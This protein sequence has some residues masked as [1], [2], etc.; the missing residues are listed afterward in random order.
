[1]SIVEVTYRGVVESETSIS[2]SLIR[3]FLVTQ[4]IVLDAVVLN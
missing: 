3:A 4:E 1:M 2:E